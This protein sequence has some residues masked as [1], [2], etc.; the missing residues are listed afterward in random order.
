MYI[1][2]HTITG[3]CIICKKN[4]FNS[5]YSDY[6]CGHYCSHLYYYR[7]RWGVSRPPVTPYVFVYESIL[8]MKSREMAANDEYNLT[9]HTNDLAIP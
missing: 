1:M 3:L 5:E 7:Q 8:E 2:I 6:F 9:K 4:I